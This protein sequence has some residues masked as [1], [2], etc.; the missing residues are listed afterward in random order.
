MHHRNSV[1]AMGE[2]CSIVRFEC[3][4]FLVCSYNAGVHAVGWHLTR[5]RHLLSLQLSN[6]TRFKMLF[7]DLGKW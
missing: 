3:G 2:F 4:V 1:K 6:G 5:E 7:A